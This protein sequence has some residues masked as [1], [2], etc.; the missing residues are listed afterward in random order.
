MTAKLILT[1]LLLGF[2]LTYSDS[3]FFFPP[4]LCLTAESSTKK[5]KCGCV[6][7]LTPI[8]PALWEAKVAG[9]FEVRSSRP[10]WPTWWNPISTK[11]TKISWAWWHV[12]VIPAT[13]EAEAGEL[14]EPRRQRLRWAEIAPL[15]SSLGNKSKTPSQKKKKVPWKYQHKLQNWTDKDHK[16]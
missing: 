11:N 1:F 2:S 16:Y 12:P 4:Q 8:I 15:H 9:S 3:T 7:W 6:Q 14:P 13:Q 5:P 10:A